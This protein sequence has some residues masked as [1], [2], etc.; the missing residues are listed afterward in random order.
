MVFRGFATDW[1]LTRDLEDAVKKD[2]DESTG[3][4]EGVANTRA[5]LDGFLE[6]CFALPGE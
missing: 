6:H 4:T 5:N 3:K 1:K 2:I